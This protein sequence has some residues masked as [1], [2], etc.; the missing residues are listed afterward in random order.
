[1][2]EKEIAAIEAR[3]E[4]ADIPSLCHA[5]REAAQRERELTEA[6]AAMVRHEQAENSREGLDEST[7]CQR[8][9]AALV[10][11]GK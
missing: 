3:P 10:G 1:M 2:N 7:E 11:G 5:L 4:P 8:A 6:L 9:R